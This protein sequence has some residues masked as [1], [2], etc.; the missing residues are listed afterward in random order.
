MKARV[1]LT[2]SQTATVFVAHLKSKRPSI[3]EG[4][5]RDDFSP[6]WKFLPFDMKKRVWDTLL[7]NSKDIQA[8]KRDPR[9][10][11]ET[12]QSY[13]VSDRTHM[14][15]SC[16]QR[17]PSSLRRCLAQPWGVRLCCRSFLAGSAPRLSRNSTIF[18]LASHA[19]Q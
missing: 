1:Q 11:R 13:H 6:R 12:T 7:F 8:R 5:D 3:P 15:S 10:A 2:D 4:A 17:G 18:G 19:A 16:P 9:R 14:T